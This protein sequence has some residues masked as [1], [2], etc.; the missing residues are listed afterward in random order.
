MWALFMI[1]KVKKQRPVNLDLTTIRFPV[2]AIASILHRV[3]GV[4]TFV[5]VGILLW[6]LGLSLSSQEGFLAASSIMDSFF[7]KFILWGILTALAYHVV[8]GIRHMLM[9]FNYLE[10]TFAAGQRS[11][12]VA[13]V[14]TVVLSILAGVLVW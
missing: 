3:S 11:A 5:A 8:V 4:I 2:T 13:F 6:L 14:I 9:D 1:K 7:V 10:E 12:R